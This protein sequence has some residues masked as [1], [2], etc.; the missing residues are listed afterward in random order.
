MSIQAILFDLDGT[1][2]RMNTDEFIEAYVKKLSTYVAHVV[3]PH[4]FAKQLMASTG[5]MIQNKEGH[6]TNKQVFDAHFYPKLESAEKLIPLI[7]HFYDAE[8]PKLQELTSSH[9]FTS[10]LIREAEE[11]GYRL[12]V[13]TNPLF[14]RSAIHQRIEWAGLSPEDFEW[15]TIYEE[16]HYTKP[17]GDYYL[18]IAKKLNLPPEACLMVGNDV[19]E[20]L[21]ASKI[22]MQT[23][24]VTDHLIDRR[25]PQ[26][27]P[28]GQGSF[29]EFYRDLCDRRGLFE[30]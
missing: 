16:S 25:E 4:A 6:L 9:D 3:D 11:Q 30:Q 22:G 5:E 19:Q 26:Y 24:L 1:L 23:Y 12:A 15:I 27:T 10:N 2:L 21:A 17:H 29:Q 8:F 13:A 28:D 14:P 20:D 7:D 18:E